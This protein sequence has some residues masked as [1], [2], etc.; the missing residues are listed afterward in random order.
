MVKLS[1]TNIQKL[2]VVRVA[3]V[4]LAMG[5]LIAPNVSHATSRH[6]H[7]PT[8]N[9][10]R[11]VLSKHDGISVV[12]RKHGTASTEG[13]VKRSGVQLTAKQAI[14]AQK[15][16]QYLKSEGE[17]AVITSGT[18]SPWEQ[19]S[20]IKSRVRSI[21]AT[22]KFPELRY[23]TARR[24]STWLRAWDY[25][26]ARHV[27]VYAP[28]SAGGMALASNHTK[29]LAIDFISGSL[30][31]LASLVRSFSYSHLAMLSPL[32]VASIAREPGCVHVNLAN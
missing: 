18:R 10:H 13:I 7:R 30:D 29:G 21:G 8:R 22:R 32:R 28:T 19:L 16:G 6:H 11:L 31:H 25:L 9:S 17:S 15:F 24:P 1:F 2:P 27:P 4:A 12:G 5:S 14:F 26:R 3:V 23:A 20:I